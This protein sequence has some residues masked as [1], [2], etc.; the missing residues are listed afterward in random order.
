MVNIIQLV[1]IMELMLI[2]GFSGSGAAAVLSAAG[3][4]AAQQKALLLAESYPSQAGRGRRD[5]WKGEP[6]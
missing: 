2:P 1:C 3:S 4:E 6:Q 5:F